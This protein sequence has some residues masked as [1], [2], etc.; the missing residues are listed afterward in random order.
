MSDEDA[1]P[2]SKNG[3]GFLSR[4]TPGNWIVITG[5]LLTALWN[6]Q[7]LTNQSASNQSSLNEIKASIANLASRDS[8]GEVQRDARERIVE[9]KT[10]VDGFRGE[11]RTMNEGFNARLSVIGERSNSSSNDIAALRATVIELKDD[12]A[13]MR[14]QTAFRS[15]SRSFE[16]GS[17]PVPGVAR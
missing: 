3:G 5:M 17:V 11:L 14:R 12:I 2:P 8:L 16:T 4:I 10:Q 7:A 1:K 6:Y 15:N 9:L 13:D